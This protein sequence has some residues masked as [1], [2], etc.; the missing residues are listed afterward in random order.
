MPTALSA[1]L[2]RDTL[3]SLLEQ[4]TPLR[5]AL[6]EQDPNRFF[7]IDRP[8][9]LEFV[10][11]TGVRIRTSARLQWTLAGMIIPLTVKSATFLLEPWLSPP[12]HLGRLNFRLQLE[13]MDL[14]NVPAMVDEQ[15]ALRANKF[16]GALGETLGWS[17]GETLSARLAMPAH[18]EPMEAF[19]LSAGAASVEVLTDALR[20]DVSLP[21]QFRLRT[22]PPTG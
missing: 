9:L 10:A 4:L 18:L 1:L 22:P 14:K 12:P 17:F 11:G 19:T 20:L 5:V 2:D 3:R 7:L 6:D 15:V 21:M 16:L 13:Q 8:D